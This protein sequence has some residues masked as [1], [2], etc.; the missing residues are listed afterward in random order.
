MVALM[1]MLTVALSVTGGAWAAVAPKQ[2]DYSGGSDWAQKGGIGG[3]LMFVGTN[4]PEKAIAIPTTGIAGNAKI[5]PVLATLTLDS[6]YEWKIDTVSV[7]PPQKNGIKA[8]VYTKTPYSAEAVVRF[9]GTPEK[10]EETVFIVSGTAVDDKGAAVPASGQ[11]RI[12]PDDPNISFFESSG[13]LS[14]PD[15]TEVTQSKFTILVFDSLTSPHSEIANHNLFNPQGTPLF[16]GSDKA[17]WHGM[18]IARSF[19]GSSIRYEFS[20]TPHTNGQTRSDVFYAGGL[21]RT[22]HQSYRLNSFTATIVGASAP[23]IRELTVKDSGYRGGVVIGPNTKFPVRL[24]VVASPDLTVTGVT[25]L[26]AQLSSSVA[27]SDVGLKVSYK[28]TAVTLDAAALTEGKTT[29]MVSASVDGKTRGLSIP[30]T[31]VTAPPPPATPPKLDKIAGVC[32]AVYDLP[33]SQTV[34]LTSTPKGIVEVTALAGPADSTSPNPLNCIWKG[35]KISASGDTLTIAQD[36]P[37][38]IAAPVSGE[39]KV[40][41]TITI[42]T[43]V[44]R[45]EQNF[46]IAIYPQGTPTIQSISPLELIMKNP[47]DET[48]QASASSGKVVLDSVDP[49]S[50]NGLQ[51]SASGSGIRVKGS[52]LDAGSQKFTLTG[53]VG[54]VKVTAE[55]AIIVADLEAVPVGDKFA[56]PSTWEKERAATRYG[57]AIP[58]KKEFIANFDANKDGNLTTDELDKVL[59]T[60]KAPNAVLTDV[61]WDMAGDTL[62]VDLK[63]VPKKGHTE[64]WYKNLFLEALTFI[65]KKDAAAYYLFKGGVEIEKVA[66]LYKKDGGNGHGGCEAGSSFLAL[67]LL[68]PLALRLRKR[69]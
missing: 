2:I 39:F 55:F 51:L 16:M 23:K 20:G 7:S 59:P 49:A 31:V 45:V 21:L 35:L 68:A 18:T 41:A 61:D 19:S 10:A 12:T 37:I 28:G 69:R 24:E 5:S 8:D 30:I 36:D 3:G 26:T 60:L 43:T 64:D 56:A 50:W 44:E 22:T 15:G 53:R 32:T 58:L 46:S 47:V 52:P 11:I 9:V 42:G 62:Y 1:L 38:A 57:L 4:Y 54:P 48:I 6:P 34:A 63:F 29:L 13:G 25:G 65:G 27:E 17:S 66:N 67:L 33:F 40:K 14:F